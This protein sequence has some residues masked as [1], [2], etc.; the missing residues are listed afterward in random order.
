M[1]FAIKAT[2]KD[3]SKVEISKART[4]NRGQWNPLLEPLAN[5]EEGKVIVLSDGLPTDKEELGKARAS[6]KKFLEKSAPAF[7]CDYTA[8]RQGLVISRIKDTGDIGEGAE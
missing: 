7:R 2:V 6:L 5:L 4:Q 3:E 8:D 1:G